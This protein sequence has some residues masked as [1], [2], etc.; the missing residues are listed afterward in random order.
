MNITI[1]FFARARDLAGAESVTLTLEPAVTL[2]GLRAELSR[3]FPP[4]AGL[5]T[6]CRLAVNAEFAQ[7]DDLLPPDAEVAVLPPV[8]GGTSR[9]TEG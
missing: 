4:L 1:C 3:R 6:H 2:G 9:R 5:L 8:S 7:E